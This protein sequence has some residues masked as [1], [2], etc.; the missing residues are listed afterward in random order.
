MEAAEMVLVST[1]NT[2]LDDLPRCHVPL[3]F[4]YEVSRTD[5][6]VEA[7]EE[8][9]RGVPGCEGRHYCGGGGGSRG[10]TKRQ[11][12]G[13]AHGYCSTV[14]RI[15]SWF[16]SRRFASLPIAHTPRQFLE[17]RR[18]FF[19]P[20]SLL[21]LPFHRR[22]LLLSGTPRRADLDLLSSWHAAPRVP[23][24]PRRRI[25][26]S[27]AASSFSSPNVA[28]RHGHRLITVPQ[29]PIRRVRALAVAVVDCEEEH[30]RSCLPACLPLH[31]LILT[32][33]LAG[34]LLQLLIRLCRP[35][36]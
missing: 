24:C 23:P 20:P 1:I 28:T 17:A 34:S 2:Q 18:F 11:K 22:A 35:R 30:G 15:F 10:A 12:M 8:E 27:A 3:G 36:S 6:T 32:L 4:I 16:G 19:E 21:I 5:P 33:A 25:A 9:G 7:E 26:A 14:A 29:P 13:P 31:S